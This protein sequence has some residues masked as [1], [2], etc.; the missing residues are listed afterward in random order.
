[1]YFDSLLYCTVLTAVICN[2]RIDNTFTSLTCWTVV[3]L[4]Y[5][6]NKNLI[7]IQQVTMVDQALSEITCIV[8]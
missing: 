7:I 1:M 4:Q 6:L 8:S 3:I 2:A 5:K